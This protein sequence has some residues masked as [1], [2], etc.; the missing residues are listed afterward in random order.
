[1]NKVNTKVDLRFHV[2]SADWLPEE[3]KLRLK[4]LYGATRMNK[5]G[6]LVIQSTVYRTQ[7]ENMQDAIDRL[8]EYLRVAYEPVQV[9]E[10]EQCRSE[11][12]DRERIQQKKMHSMKKK[13]R[14][15]QSSSGHY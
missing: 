2:D 12:S 10:H 15:G 11:R 8:R 9:M 6:E 3:V 1:M 13:G 4:Q 5:Q 7:K 14:S